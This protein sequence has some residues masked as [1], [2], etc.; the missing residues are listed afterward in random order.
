MHLKFGFIFNL[1]FSLIEETFMIV[2]GLLCDIVVCNNK[3]EQ[4]TSEHH[5]GHRATSLPTTAQ[6]WN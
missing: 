6:Y 1:C 4:K 5:V 2:V 3:S